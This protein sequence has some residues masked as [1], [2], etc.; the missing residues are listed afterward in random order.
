MPKKLIL[1]AG[2]LLAAAPWRVPAAPV[3]T[4]ATNGA[5][6]TVSYRYFDPVKQSVCGR[7]ANPVSDGYLLYYGPA[8]QIK[9][10][11]HPADSTGW[12][13]RYDTAGLIAE[14][15]EL[16]Q[17]SVL[18]R[19][20]EFTAGRPSRVYFYH[21][22]RNPFKETRF[23]YRDGRLFMQKTTLQGKLFSFR[24]F[25]YHPTG[26]LQAAALY[27]QNGFNVG[28]ILYRTDSRGRIIEE[29]HYSWGVLR[30]IVQISW[31]GDCRSGET[32]R[33]PRAGDPLKDP[34]YGRPAG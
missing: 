34:F 23:L 30:R 4:D 31:S 1:A 24:R 28:R 27:N 13:Y 8:F 6:A 5:A 12:I 20:W 22:Y 17:N 11:Y 16:R 10:A 18:W 7:L 21:G 26:E 19:R 3:W 2:L 32:E 15:R 29:L 9:A 14:C 33:K 25:S